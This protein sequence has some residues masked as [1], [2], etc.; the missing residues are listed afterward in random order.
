MALFPEQGPT[1]K[2]TFS[3]VHQWQYTNT[4]EIERCGTAIHLLIPMHEHIH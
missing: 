1:D 4:P 2:N 3:T